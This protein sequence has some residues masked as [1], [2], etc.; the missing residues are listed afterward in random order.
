[1][2]LRPR[3]LP[4]IPE[5]EE[6]HHTLETYLAHEPEPPDYLQ[7]FHDVLEAQ[8]MMGLVVV[9]VVTAVSASS[10]GLLVGRMVVVVALWI[11]GLMG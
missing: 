10:L 9:C 4:T 6:A 5:D 7:P 1:M 8:G 3:R 2:S 11:E